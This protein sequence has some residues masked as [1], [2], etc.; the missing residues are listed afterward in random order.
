MDPSEVLYQCPVLK[1]PFKTL[2]HT[3]SLMTLACLSRLWFNL[4]LKLI[5]FSIPRFHSYTR[6]WNFNYNFTF[7]LMNNSSPSFWRS[8]HY[9]QFDCQKYFWLW[10]VTHQYLKIYNTTF[11][12]RT[13]WIRSRRLRAR[14]QRSSHPKTSQQFII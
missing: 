10:L 13:L 6:V 5:L 12:L 9:L 7:L 11:L 14:S 2:L 8:K 1:L 3:L 4:Y